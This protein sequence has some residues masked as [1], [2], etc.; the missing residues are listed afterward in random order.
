MTILKRK[1]V[2]IIFIWLIISSVF[3]RV[4]SAQTFTLEITCKNL[5]ENMVVLGEVKGDNFI[6][7]DSAKALKNTV[8][9]TFS[10]NN[11]PKVYRVIFGQTMYAK[12]MNE[13]PQQLDFIFNNENI[14]LETDFNTPEESILVILSE[15]NRIWFEFRQKEKTYQTELNDL[16]LEIDFYHENGTPEKA[17]VQIL[18]YNQ[19]QKDR[20][21]FLLNLAEKNNKLFAS[22]LIKT[23]REPFLDGNLSP[24]QRKEIFQNEFLKTVDFSDE[25]LI[26]S[27]SYTDKVFNYLVSFNQRNFTTIQRENAYKTAVDRIVSETNENQKVYEFILDYLVKGFEILKMDGLIAYIADKYGE[28]TCQTDEKTTL[29]RKLLSQKMKQ[30][31]VVSD[32]TINDINGNPITLSNVL[33]EKN[34]L[35][36]WASWCPHCKEMLPFIYNWVKE[37]KSAFE[38]IAISLDTEKNDWQNTVNSLGIEAWYNLSDL[39]NWDGKVASDYNIYATPTLFVVDKNLKILATPVTISD[40]ISLKL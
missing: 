35:I 1:L 29:E 40:L 38:V 37:Q 8:K 19:L 5:P 25:S 22:K 13:A 30:G 2:H 9:F 21:Q 17:A 6:P 28:T 20:D 15:E 18:K 32:F 36:F 12:I 26:W 34:L 24:L 10:G 27:Q 16:K 7:T 33:K 14:I 23:F 31:T 11:Q 3:N 39:Q 4:T